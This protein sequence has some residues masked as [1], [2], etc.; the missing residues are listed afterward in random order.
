MP[1]L[2]RGDMSKTSISYQGLKADRPGSVNIY[3]DQ[4]QY[5][6]ETGDRPWLEGFYGRLEACAQSDREKHTGRDW[7]R[8]DACGARSTSFD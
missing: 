2:L 3:E 8:P 5:E 7:F 1:R 4:L 6:V